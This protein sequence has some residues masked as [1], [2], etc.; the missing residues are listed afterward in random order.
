MDARLVALIHACIGP[1]FFAYLAGLLVV[2]SKMW[3][4]APA[5]TSTAGNRVLLA[6]WITFAAIY[7]Q[8]ILG[9]IVRHM[10]LTASPQAFR[11]ALSLHLI[12]AGA[13]ALQIMFFSGSAVRLKAARSW[14]AAPGIGLIALVLLQVALGIGAY[15]AKYSWPAWMGNYDFAAGYVVQEKSLLQS[16]I[17]TAHVANGSLMLFVSALAAT[18]ASRLFFPALRLA[19]TADPI[20][21]R[22]AA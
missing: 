2:T 6:A 7:A 18:R 21:M 5:A 14:L 20:G 4:S 17:T 10:P 12:L 8:L 15:V 11:A 13:V 22:C 1:L 3:D 9:A 19:A 16:L